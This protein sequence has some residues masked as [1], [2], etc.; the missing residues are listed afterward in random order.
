MG[1]SLRTNPQT[2]WVRVRKGRNYPWPDYNGRVTDVHFH[3]AD[4]LAPVRG[5]LGA[6]SIEQIVR[7]MGALCEDTPDKCLA[8][9]WKGGR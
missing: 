7:G 4:T 9:G 8:T 3:D 1:F 6:P 5:G 2:P